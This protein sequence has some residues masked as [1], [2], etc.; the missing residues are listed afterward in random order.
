VELK[1]KEML[2]YIHNYF[3][4][5][6]FE[7]T[8]KIENHQIDNSKIELF[9]GQYFMIKGSIFNDGIW[10]YD[11][12]LNIDLNKDENDDYLTDEEFEGEI[13][14]LAIP[15]DVIA[16]CDEI[17]DWEVKNQDTLNGIYQSESFGGYSYSLKSG[18]SN[19][20]GSSESLSWRD[21]FGNRLKAYRKLS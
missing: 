3:V 13:Y 1:L 8:I 6:V 18:K 7:G 5:D 12:N 20:N 4:M 16:I 17:K 19:T 14:L 21:V 10:R 2:D 11:E 15:R 9:N